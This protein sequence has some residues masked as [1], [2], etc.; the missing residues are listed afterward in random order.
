MSNN[1]RP[2]TV[3]LFFLSL[4]LLSP[5]ATSSVFA[6]RRDCPARRPNCDNNLVIK[7]TLR[8]GVINVHSGPGEEFTAINVLTAETAALGRNNY[9]I[10]FDCTEE[11]N[12]DGTVNESGAA[13]NA[14]AWVK[15]ETAEQMEGWVNLCEIDFEEGVVD[16]DTLLDVVEPAC[17]VHHADDAGS[18]PESDI[19]IPRDALTTMVNT[20]TAREWAGPDG[21]S[22]ALGRIPYGEIV[23]LLGVHSS[24]HWVKVRCRGVTG[25]VLRSDIHM[26][27]GHSGLPIVE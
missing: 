12:E 2:I 20:T 27:N 1:I 6:I 8:A 19:E 3:K 21:C 17:A 11:I 5:L 22:G 15:I 7:P 24:G 25:W 26:D 14:Q 4:I 23:E 16:G 18:L 10:N 9:D 13:H